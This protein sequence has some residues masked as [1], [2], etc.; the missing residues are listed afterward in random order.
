MTTNE[1]KW[2]LKTLISNTGIGFKY[3]TRPLAKRSLIIVN[4]TTDIVIEGFPR[5]GNTY[6]TALLY[7]LKPQVNIARHRHEIGHLIY[8]IELEKPIICIVREPLD[9]IIS[10]HIREELSIGFCVKYYLEFHRY[11]EQHKDK[12]KII[13]FNV[14]VNN[15]IQVVKTINQI[16]SFKLTETDFNEK[17]INDIK[18]I[19]VEMENKEREF[20]GI[21]SKDI[22]ATHL[23]VPTEER[24][25]YKQE[26]IK[27]LKLKKHKKDIQKAKQIYLSLIKD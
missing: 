22:R 11:L 13:D 15:P 14:L 26:V 2:R 12:I 25:K 3:I 23:A 16:T 4:N 5:S 19:V 18:E 24:L 7:Y 6:C 9:S 17:K 1:I 21:H 10:L 27:K 8:A 20:M